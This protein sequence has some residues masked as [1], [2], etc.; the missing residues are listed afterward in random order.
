MEILLVADIIGIASFALGGLL[1]AVHKKLDILGVV[2]MA[3]LSALG[4]GIIRDVLADRVPFAFSHYYPSTTVILTL[5][6]AILLKV[7]KQEAHKV[8]NKFLFI[9]FDTIGLAAFSITG[10][11]VGIESG[12]NLFGVII[13]SFAT[14][15]GGGIIRDILLNE[16][17]LVLRKEF[18]GTVAILTAILM[19][20]LEHFSILSSIATTTIFIVSILL[21]LY[22]YKKGWKLP[23]L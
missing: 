23:V 2:I 4:G 11:I 13:L 18:Y 6:I 10:A 12:F 21:R 22:A 14:A 19:F 3:S 17:P 8:S 5:F 16:V 1:I 9:L 20:A 15:L 7:H